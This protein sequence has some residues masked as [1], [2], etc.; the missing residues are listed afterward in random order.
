[1]AGATVTRL[2]PRPTGGTTPAFLRYRWEHH[3]GHV[4]ITVV[5]AAGLTL[6]G[7]MALFGLPPV[8]LHGPL[9]RFGIMDP[10]CGGTRAARFTAQGEWALAWQYNPLG[11]AAVVGAAAATLRAL[12]GLVSGRW[13]TAQLHWTPRR[14]RL[15]VTF[16]IALLVALTIRQQ[17]HVDL[18]TQDSWTL[19]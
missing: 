1:V 4:V 18:L 9:H 7:T 5:A 3:D 15:A 19:R 16:G 12:V 2:R 14:R 6:A 17:L 10:L 13:L 11:I 8:D